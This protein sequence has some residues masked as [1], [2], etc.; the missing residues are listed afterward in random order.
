MADKYIGAHVTVRLRT[1]LQVTGFVGHIELSSHE[2]TLKEGT[3]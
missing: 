2:M 1:G 3:L